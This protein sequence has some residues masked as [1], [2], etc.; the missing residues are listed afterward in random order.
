MRWSLEM[1]N[2]AADL[3]KKG[4]GYKAA[5]TELGISRETVRE[6]YYAY[7]ALGREGLCALGVRREYPRQVKIAC[8]KARVDERAGMVETMRRFGVANRHQ[9]MAWCAEYSEKGDAAFLEK[10]RAR[11][12]LS[13]SC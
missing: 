12:A 3:F 13:C 8:A 7:R 5:S 11:S 9:I 1:R 10:P 2:K 4:Y 6:W